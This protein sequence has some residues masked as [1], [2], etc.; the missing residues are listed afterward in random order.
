MVCIVITL[1]VLP[2]YT[3]EGSSECLKTGDALSYPGGCSGIA[4]L[5]LTLGQ[6]K[7]TLHPS[8]SPPA[9]EFLLFWFCYCCLLACQE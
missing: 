9:M 1:F 8:P 3:Q 6:T 4:L 2:N 7:I 5:G